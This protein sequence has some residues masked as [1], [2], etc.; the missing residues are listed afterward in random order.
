[1]ACGHVDNICANLERV[2]EKVLQEECPAAAEE[3]RE[4]MVD[5]SEKLKCR[6]QEG[7]TAKLSFWSDLPYLALGSQAALPPRFFGGVD[8]AGGPWQA[9]TDTAMGSFCLPSAVQISLSG[10]MSVGIWRSVHVHWHSYRNS[11]S[12]LQSISHSFEDSCRA[13]PMPQTSCRAF[14][15]RVIPLASCR[16]YP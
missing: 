15:V 3:L 10:A 6:L 9:F 4:W 7:L 5:F 12:L 14:P 13:F 1:M 11:S 2:S 8:F 16:A